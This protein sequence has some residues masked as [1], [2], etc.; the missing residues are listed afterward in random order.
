MATTFQIRKIH[1]LKNLLN[2]SGNDYQSLLMGFDVESSKELSYGAAC[3]LLS[4]L[5][6]KAVVLNLWKKQP[7][8][9][10]D[11]DRCETMATPK[12]LRM[13]ESLW[14]EISYFDNDNFAK[15]SLR[16]FLQKKF[17]VDDV[18]FLTKQKATKIIPIIIE[19]NNKA[20]AK[21]A[22]VR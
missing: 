8:K 10:H 17:K 12:Q 21:R 3:E 20:K 16:T 13:I 18:M 11:L 2:L 6:D 14:R 1:I 9:Y 22:D 4:L 19:M 15:I 7:K 5:E